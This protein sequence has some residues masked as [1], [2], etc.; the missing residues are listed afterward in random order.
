MVNRPDVRKSWTGE[1][2][3]ERIDAL[4]RFDQNTSGV[5]HSETARRLSEGR[6]DIGPFHRHWVSRRRNSR[7]ERQ[8]LES[9]N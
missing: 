9:F 7:Q 3:S 1:I 5:S 4:D 6:D 8:S 2:V